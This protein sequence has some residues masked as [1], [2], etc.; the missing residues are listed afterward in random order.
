MTKAG[1]GVMLRLPGQAGVKVSQGVSRTSKGRRIMDILIA[2]VISVALLAA[3]LG[4]VR[5]R[6]KLQRSK[7]ERML[8]ELNAHASLQEMWS[9]L[10]TL[11]WFKHHE[12]PEDR[13]SRLKDIKVD[14]PDEDFASGHIVG[15]I[16]GSAARYLKERLNVLST[17]EEWILFLN[18]LIEQITHTWSD[19]GAMNFANGFSDKVS[20]FTS[21]GYD[22]EKD[23]QYWLDSRK[24]CQARE[25]EKRRRE[26]VIKSGLRAAGIKP[27]KF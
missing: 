2:I 21:K 27:P 4:A 18:T 25:N 15:E 10:V 22:L 16:F 1:F 12:R 20:T 23:M 6:E 19:R 24:S 5:F 13:P 17:D 26:K 3:T 8:C 7:R 14:V 9:H 11:G